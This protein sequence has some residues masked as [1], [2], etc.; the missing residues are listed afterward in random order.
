MVNQLLQ[1]NA[2]GWRRI[3][4]RRTIALTGRWLLYACLACL[5]IAPQA[6][7]VNVDAVPRSGTLTV[8][9]SGMKSDAGALVYAMW[10]DPEQWLGD[11]GAVRT[12]A[13]PIEDGRSMVVL[14]A[15]PYGE[16]AISAFHDENGNERLDTGMFRIPK[17]P[18]GT[19]NDA[20][21]RFGPPKYEDAR[22]QL[23]QPSSTITI[24]IKKLF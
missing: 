12:G 4:R 13:S 9:F 5:P 16:Y 21:A 18:L 10:A 7:P 17:E 24:A 20:K 1:N 6:D 8:H 15:L 22:F 3:G 2:R 14:E 19:S 11:G 23:N